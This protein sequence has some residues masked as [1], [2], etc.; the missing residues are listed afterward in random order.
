MLRV[1]KLNGEPLLLS[2]EDVDRIEKSSATDT[3]V[4]Y[5]SSKKEVVQETP[6]AI[7][8]TIGPKAALLVTYSNNTSVVAIL[9]M[10][11]IKSIEEYPGNKSRISFN[12]KTPLVVEESLPTLQAQIV[13]AGGGG[14]CLPI[15]NFTWSGA[16][17]YLLTI[18]DCGSPYVVDLSDLAPDGTVVAVLY[19]PLTR[20]LII[21]TD[22][23]NQFIV[24][25][26]D[27]LVG[28]TVFV[29]PDGSDDPLTGGKRERIDRQFATPW[30]AIASAQSGDTVVVYPGTY[31]WPNQ[32]TTQRLIKNGV[33]MFCHPG[34]KINFTST[35][36]TTGT[37][38]FSDDNVQVIGGIYGQGE[39]TFLG[40]SPGNL[41]IALQNIN[42]EVTIECKTF[43]NR[44]RLTC[45]GAKKFI[46]RGEKHSGGDTSII[47]MFNATAQP[48]IFIHGFDEVIQD[49]TYNPSTAGNGVF[50][51][52]QL[53]NFTEQGSINIKAKRLQYRT[54]FFSQGLFFCQLLSCPV[55][56]DTE[57]EY[58]GDGTGYDAHYNLIGSS[59]ACSALW[60]VNVS[61][62][63][64]SG[65][66]WRW[67]VGGGVGPNYGKFTFT[68]VHKTPI[69]GTIN[70]AG[71]G[72]FVGMSAGSKLDMELDLQVENRTTTLDYW[73]DCIINSANIHYI[74]GK[75][76]FVTPDVT[77]AP[78]R[79][80]N[81][82]SNGVPYLKNLAV[83]TD[84]TYLAEGG[85][86]PQL[87]VPC[88]SVFSNKGFDPVLHAA[89]IEPLTVS[90]AVK[91]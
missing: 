1:T 33:N 72:T 3:I 24:T 52:Y 11:G 74:T 68:G 21:D 35:A 32:V 47:R 85:G 10:H 83:E 90:P 56:I 79:I 7:Y 46:M 53:R 8:A 81:S 70:A 23:P 18:T 37:S 60:N 48:T 71:R 69:S 77:A 51:P 42:S 30:A 45:T 50:S 9:M 19:N 49:N 13:S 44:T 34:V 82:A 75:L 67:G 88:M 86:A 22:E 54:S 87:S 15:N 91:V 58:L 80:P 26:P 36:T 6:A 65:M 17:N 78:F 12:S 39:F 57:I 2:N 40:T 61:S 31:T 76:R 59:E 38:P 89:A 4:Y 73:Y 66:G 5:S 25:V 29:S 16:P 84:S 41:T 62:K 28:N 55:N 20:E 14:G 43:Y 63:N 27:F 64:H